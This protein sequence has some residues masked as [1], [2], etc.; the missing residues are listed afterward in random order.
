MDENSL[1]LYAAA[2]RLEQRHY[3]NSGMDATCDAILSEAYN[4]LNEN[5]HRWLNAPADYWGANHS[6]DQKILLANRAFTSGS[7]ETAKTQ[8][9]E[10]AHLYLGS[11]MGHPTINYYMDECLW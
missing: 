7:L 9:H 4:R 11:S 8:F 6:L 5:T 10:A 2:W 1:I 3:A